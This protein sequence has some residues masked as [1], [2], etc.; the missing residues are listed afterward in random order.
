MTR[1]SQA[2]LLGV[3]VLLCAQA[4]DAAAQTSATMK[5]VAGAVCVCLSK[6][7]ISTIMTMEQASAA[8]AAC[9]TN[10]RAGL[11][12]LAR[13]RKV[14]VSDQAA[15]RALDMDVANELVAQGCPSL[16]QLMARFR[17]ARVPDAADDAG[18]GLTAGRLVRIEN[19][20]FRHLVVTDASDRES[21]FIWLR[22]F[23]GSEKFIET[24]D[25]YIGK[26]LK[27]QWRET[28][29]FLPSANGYFKVK[30]IT[31]IEVQ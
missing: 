20:D 16:A 7:D 26:S 1:T 17:N 11:L 30:E 22:Y 23:K 8:I 21:T 24:P 28:E 19:K 9:F 12:D 14:D 5:K 18:S 4:R 13:E 25:A 31:G 2:L 6:T 3:L 27:V 15:T 29:V 10:N